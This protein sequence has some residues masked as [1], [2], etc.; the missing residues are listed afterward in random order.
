MW[1]C[2]TSVH[3]LHIRSRGCGYASFCAQT[4][5][6]GCAETSARKRQDHQA[7][8]EA[9]LAHECRGRDWPCAELWERSRAPSRAGG[10]QY[11]NTDGTIPLV[12]W[13]QCRLSLARPLFGTADKESFRA[14]CS[15]RR[16]GWSWYS[17]AMLRRSRSKFDS[18]SG[19]GT[20]GGVDRG[21]KAHQFA[22]PTTTAQRAVALL[23]LTHPQLGPGAHH[24]QGQASDLMPYSVLPN[25]RAISR[26]LS[27]QSISVN[28]APHRCT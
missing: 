7:D 10:L 22:P 3:K 12:R 16:A 8:D 28:R 23:N 5:H 18:L 25:E 15:L 9:H 26:L 20:N 11:V 2:K 17:P 6:R 1:I 13:C 19:R 21:C 24:R 4:S 27:C 14:P